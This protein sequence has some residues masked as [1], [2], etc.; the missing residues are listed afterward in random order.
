MEPP[1]NIKSTFKQA[2]P[3]KSESDWE[4]EKKTRSICSAKAVMWSTTDG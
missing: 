2:E 3:A 1:K 4:N